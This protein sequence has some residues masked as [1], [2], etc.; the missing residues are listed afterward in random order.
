MLMLH[1]P[2]ML[3]QSVAAVAAVHAVPV[4]TLHLPWPGHCVAALAGWQATLVRLHLPL[5]VGQSVA[6]VAALQD[7]P[8]L[9]L[10]LPTDGHCDATFAGW[11]DV[12]VSMLHLPLT[13]V[14]TAAAFAVVQAAFVTV[15]LPTSVGVQLGFRTQDGHSGLKPQASQPGGSQ[16][17]TQT[18]PVLTM[19]SQ[20]CVE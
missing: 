10:H 6:A 3:G 16:T 4:L 9:T 1:L 15:H 8:V 20:V 13:G 18:S 2:L 19:L 17:L 5:M 7:V 11:H 14:Q 12:P